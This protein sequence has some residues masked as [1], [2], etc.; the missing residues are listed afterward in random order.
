[1]VDK[2]KNENDLPGV[3]DQGGKHGDNKVAP[4][5]RLSRK[6]RYGTTRSNALNGPTT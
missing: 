5:R 6:T 4:A 3:Q 2:S 1:M